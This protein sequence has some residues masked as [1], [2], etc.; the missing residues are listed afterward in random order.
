MQNIEASDDKNLVINQRARDPG[1]PHVWAFNAMLKA[2][3]EQLGSKATM[4][5]RI[6]GSW[7]Q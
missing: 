3:V 6:A 5:P 7:R 1:S 4:T 2:I